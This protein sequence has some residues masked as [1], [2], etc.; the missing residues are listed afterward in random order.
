LIAHNRTVDQIREFL[1]VECPKSHVREME[2][3]ERGF[4]PVDKAL[5]KAYARE[6]MVTDEPLLIWL[7]ASSFKVPPLMVIFPAMASTV[8][9]PAGAPGG[10]PLA[11]YGADISWFSSD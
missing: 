10:N 3:D 11:S 9:L 6:D 7:E 8:V 4:S 1:E 2:D 5:A